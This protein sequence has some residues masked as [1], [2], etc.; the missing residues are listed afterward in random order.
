SA[1]MERFSPFSNFMFLFIVI[2]RCLS[3]G[4]IF[5]YGSNSIVALALLAGVLCEADLAAM[6]QSDGNDK[7]AILPLAHYTFVWHY[8]WLFGGFIMLFFCFNFTILTLLSYGIAFIVSRIGCRYYL[9]DGN[10]MSADLISAVGCFMET[11][12][13]L[14][15]LLCVG[16]R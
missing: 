11:I 8:V 6:P 10:P 7:T 14:L 15:A 12:V 1:V 16:G 13:L 4:M 5:Y 9:R 3:L 2:I